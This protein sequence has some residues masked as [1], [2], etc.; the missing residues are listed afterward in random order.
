MSRKFISNSTDEN[1]RVIDKETGEIIEERN[2]TTKTSVI[3]LNGKSF[4]LTFFENVGKLANITN[5]KERGILDYL[6]EF[7]EYNNNL[8]NV[9]PY[10]KDRICKRLDINPQTFANSISKLKKN[11]IMFSVHNEE[12]KIQKGTYRL[13]PELVWKGSLKENAKYLKIYYEALTEE[14]LQNNTNNT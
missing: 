6:M 2:T 14:E 11:E 13:N 10:L 4:Y 12:G 9:T 8:V 1:L 7:C 3:P 5:G